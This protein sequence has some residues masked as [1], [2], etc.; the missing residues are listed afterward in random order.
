MQLKKNKQGKLNTKAINAAILAIILIVVLFE[1]YA[2]LVPEA[3]DAGESLNDSNRCTAVGCYWNHSLTTP[4]CLNTSNSGETEGCTT[5][6][7]EIPFGNLFD[8]A[9]FIFVIIMALLIVLVVKS[10]LKGK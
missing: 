6:G 8:G 10:L 9:G 3:Q 5:S 4:R 1:L 2:E 7:Y